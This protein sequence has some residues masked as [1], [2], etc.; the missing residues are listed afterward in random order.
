MEIWRSNL[1]KTDALAKQMAGKVLLRA[2]FPAEQADRYLGQYDIR[3]P[4]TVLEIT[5]KRMYTPKRVIRD[6]QGNIVGTI[7]GT[8]YPVP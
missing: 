7:E 6:N 3:D 2:G 8:P 1:R 4:E 5:G